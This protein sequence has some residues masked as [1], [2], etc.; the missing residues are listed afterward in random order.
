MFHVLP[1][2]LFLRLLDRLF[3]R[4]FERLLLR[5]LRPPAGRFLFISMLDLLRRTHKFRQ[6]QNATM[7]KSS[8]NI[9]IASIGPNEIEYFALNLTA[10]TTWIQSDG[11]S[12]APYYQHEVR[13]F[14]DKLSKNPLRS[15]SPPSWISYH[16]EGLPWSSIGWG[17]NVWIRRDFDPTKMSTFMIESL[18]RST[19]QF[20]SR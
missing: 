8:I 2:R 3:D 16:K 11:T 13:Y 19:S 10:R 20:P 9:A 7:K 1:D 14:S 15:T 6:K 17:I 4:S 5:V 12:S 18:F